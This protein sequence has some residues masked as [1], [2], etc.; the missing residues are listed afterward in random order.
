VLE[1][2]DKGVSNDLLAIDIRKALHHLGEI[3]GQITTDDLLDNI[4]SKF[5]I[6]K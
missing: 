6:G 5:Y 3:T 1:G 4:F 2:I